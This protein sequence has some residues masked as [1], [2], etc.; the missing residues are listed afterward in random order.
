MKP[1][2]DPVRALVKASIIVV[3]VVTAVICL[4][5][6]GFH[7]CQAGRLMWSC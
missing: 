7:E 5:V 2:K 1:A 4:F 3:V 6:F